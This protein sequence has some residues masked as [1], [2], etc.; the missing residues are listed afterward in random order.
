[1][2]Y[3]CLKVDHCNNMKITY[4]TLVK[5]LRDCSN[6]LRIWSISVLWSACMHDWV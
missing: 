4:I 1:M 5:D 6:T 3:I 2:L